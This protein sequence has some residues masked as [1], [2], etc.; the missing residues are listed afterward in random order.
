[1]G[2]L[3]NLDAYIAEKTEAILAKNGLY[4]EIIDEFEK[5][6]DE[7]LSN[8]NATKNLKTAAEN[9]VGAYQK[10]ESADKLTREINNMR[11]KAKK[12]L[13]SRKYEE[14]KSADYYQ[15]VLDNTNKTFENGSFMM[16]KEVTGEEKSKASVTNED[17]REFYEAFYR[18]LQAM[19]NFLGQKMIFVFVDN[20]GVLYES[21]IDEIIENKNSFVF[22]F[23]SK[24]GFTARFNTKE[25]E[26]K[27]KRVS[28][29]NSNTDLTT[30]KDIYKE[31]LARAKIS[32]TKL[33]LGD[34]PKIMWKADIWRMM[35]VATMGDLAESYASYAY[36]LTNGIIKEEFFDGMIEKKV[37]TFMTGGVASK[38]AKAGERSELDVRGLISSV[39]NVNNMKGTYAG[40]FSSGKG[41][42]EYAAKSNGASSQG[43]IEDYK[44]AKRIVDGGDIKKIILGDYLMSLKRSIGDKPRNKIQRGIKQK[45]KDD[46]ENL[47]GETV[48]KDG[49]F[50]DINF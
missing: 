13:K 21:T 48:A 4:Q 11:S 25:D 14:G 5:K 47:L 8:S 43:Y 27:K 26:M 30:L 6:V 38:A 50:K 46:M 17:L 44:V 31:I 42:V 36:G 28:D 23:S 3:D 20:N 49:Q 16:W 9:F 29:I 2:K 19:Q 33:H 18:Y 12:R 45:I 7:G 32:R 24:G 22:G 37:E 41:G 35:N 1:M 10:I 39:I 40:D 15:S 34:K